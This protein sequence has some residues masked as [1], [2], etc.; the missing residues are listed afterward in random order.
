MPGFQRSIN[1]QPAPGV[2]GDFCSANPWASELAGEATFTADAAGVA[3]GRFA[4]AL[5]A[6]GVV[7][8]AKPGGA[9]RLGFVARHQPAL[10]TAFLGQS[11]N[12]I[13]GGL[14]ITMHDAGDFWARF[15]APATIGQKVF[16]LDIDGTCAAFAPLSVNAGYTETMFWVHSVAAAG[17]VA[18][19]SH[20]PVIL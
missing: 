14:E 17:E 5:V 12:L 1:T 7:T 6:T 19:I 20:R 11:N 3:V 4:R 8:N 16:A 2:E 9:S 15:A 18:K 10:I 13:P